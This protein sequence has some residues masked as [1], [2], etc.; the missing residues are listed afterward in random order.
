MQIVVSERVVE[1]QSDLASIW[2]F[3]S[4]TDRTNRA[5]GLAKLDL[6]PHSDKSAARFLVTTELGGFRVEYEERPF[7]WVYL[8]HFKIL[9]RMRSGPISWIEMAFFL[10]TTPQRK[11]RVSLRL[12]L[13][14]KMSILSPFLRVRASQSLK[15][16]EKEIIAFDAQLASGITPRARTKT[17][18]H[19]D[20]LVR[21]RHSLETSIEPALA[22][23]IA[24]FVRNADDTQVSQIRPF[25]LAD[26]WSLARRDVLAACLAAVAAGMLELRWEVV[27]PSCRNAAS[28]LPTLA[29]LG[30]HAS[31]QLCDIAFDVDLDQSVEATFAPTR[32]VREVDAGPYCIGGPART[33]HVVAQVIL[34]AKGTSSVIAPAEPGPYRLFVRGGA[35]QRVEVR[36]GAPLRIELKDT[37]FGAETLA[38]APSGAI[39]VTSTHADERHAK[40]ERTTFSRGAATARE[41]TAMPGF[42]RQFSSDVLRPGL[43]LKVS[44]V[45]LFFSDLTGSTALYSA[46]GDAAAFK[47]VQ[48]HFEVLLSIIEKNRGALVKTIGDAVMAAFSDDLDGLAAAIATLHAFEAFRAHDSLRSRTHIKLGV[49]GGP[50][51]AV[52]AN[53]VLDYFGQTAN[54]AARLQGEARAGEIVCE[55]SLADHAIASGVLDPALIVE[56]SQARL[57]GVD[58]PIAV[59]KIS[60]RSRSSAPE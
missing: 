8:K 51:F 30:E 37:D 43:A 10:D 59:A 20:A 27:C 38:I 26:E 18:A 16:M 32:A 9:R 6:V 35:A 46:A 7:E 40:L 53:G 12:S 22:R 1:C 3:L 50:C 52:T 31:C 5:I 15:R 36:A 2:T 11:T 48:D 47:L 41:V 54:I 55:A 60:L 23:R 25:D 21:A 33:P 19:E 39:A 34:P 4:D 57:R 49:F 58:H 14:P 13:L 17:A 28:Q 44:R 29:D 56:R 45:G 42:R 24:D